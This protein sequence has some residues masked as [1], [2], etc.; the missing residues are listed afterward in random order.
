MFD[1]DFWELTSFVVT[2]FGFPLALFVFLYEQRRERANEEAGVYQ[3][4][5]NSYTDFLKVVLEHPDLHLATRPSTPDLTPEQRERMMV[6]LDM[7][8]S[9]FE[10]AYL[11]AW[12]PR[13]NPEQQRRWN[14]WE[15]FMRDWVR[16][17]DF[18]L[19]MET[20]LRGE[21]PEFAAYIRKLAAEERA[22]AAA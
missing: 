1:R 16:R 19:E 8:M 10:R 3:L 2:S 20:L 12:R 22:T 17:D 14:V 15:D 11:T 7:L 5:S 13:M 18:Y 4:L 9:I 6:L 21:D